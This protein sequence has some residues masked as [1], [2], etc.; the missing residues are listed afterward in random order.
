MKLLENPGLPAE[1]SSQT[2]IAFAVGFDPYY[3]KEL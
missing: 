1:Y 2:G 3:T